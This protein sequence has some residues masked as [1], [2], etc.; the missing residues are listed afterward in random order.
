MR[1]LV[2]I[3]SWDEFVAPLDSDLQSWLGGESVPAMFSERW[4]PVWAR[5]VGPTVDFSDSDWQEEE[6]LP[7]NWASDVLTE[8]ESPDDRTVTLAFGSTGWTRVWVNE[9][10]VHKNSVRRLYFP[11]SDRVEVPLKKGRNR[12]AVK[13]HVNDDDV[14]AFSLSVVSG[15]EGLKACA[16]RLPGTNPDYYPEWARNE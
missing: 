3:Q 7:E 12:L 1:P 16:P 8:I 6:P 2:P 5:E 13:V 4:L 11:D 14:T 9:N 10:E 15:G